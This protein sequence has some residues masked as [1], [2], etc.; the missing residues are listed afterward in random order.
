M[1]F[2]AMIILAITV[3]GA[4]MILGEFSSG[5]AA[6]SGTLALA[7]AGLFALFAFGSS[8]A[9]SSQVLRNP[10][11]HVKI[12]RLLSLLSI[13]FLI[14]IVA[15]FA[16]FVLDGHIVIPAVA[17]TVIDFILMRIHI[18]AGWGLVHLTTRHT[19]T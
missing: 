10:R 7:T 9:I 14:E 3:Y 18:R 12:L 5:L 4:I 16:A 13:L 15:L 6:M 8:A 17:G 19:D 2:T 11:S 1:I